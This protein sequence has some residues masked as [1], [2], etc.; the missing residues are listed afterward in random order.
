MTFCNFQ[1]ITDT[2]SITAHRALYMKSTS[3]VY[4]VCEF[5]TFAIIKLCPVLLCR[6]L[7]PAVLPIKSLRRSFAHGRSSARRVAT[8][9]KPYGWGPGWRYKTYFIFQ[10][11]A[12]SAA[13]T[14]NTTWWNRLQFRVLTS[15]DDHA[16]WL[17][18]TESLFPLSPK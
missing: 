10:K 13:I 7:A 2:H 6:T 3:H 8:S 9:K 14:G 1:S 11:K 5:P 12:L 4:A 18:S 15:P 17:V 16:P